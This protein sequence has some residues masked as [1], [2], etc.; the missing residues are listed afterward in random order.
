MTASDKEVVMPWK[1]LSVDEQR[2]SV[3][4]RVLTLKHSV[5]Q[6]A[7]EA[8]VSRKTL[9]KWLKRYR[10]CG[11]ICDSSHAPRRSPDKTHEVIEQRVL[12]LRRRY[13]W[14]PRKIHRILSD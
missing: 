14:G 11:Q 12:A 9:H 8:G 7:R 4:H 13:Y 2:L 6:A 1:E 5:T 10:E 3:I